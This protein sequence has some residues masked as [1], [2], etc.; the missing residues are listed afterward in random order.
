MTER[1]SDSALGAFLAR[2]TTA[3]VA[4]SSEG[5]TLG[6]H[7]DEIARAHGAEAQI[8]VQADGAVLSVLDGGDE[9]TYAVVSKQQVTRLDRFSDLIPVIRRAKDPDADLRALTAEL[10]AI[11]SSPPIYPMWTKPLGIVLFTIGF[12]PSVQ[13]TWAQIGY[14]A[15][16]G[17]VVAMVVMVADRVAR[18]AVLAPLLASF[19]VASVVLVVAAGTGPSDARIL[20]M[21]PGLFFFIPG[22]I[23]S[24]AMFDLAAGR[25]T[26]GA[27]QL[28]N[29]VFILLM[30]LTGVVFGA[31]V[32]GTD[33]STLFG[34]PADAQF[35]DLVLWAGWV[36]FT[37]GFMLAFSVRM[38]HFGWVLLV[39]L[40]VFGASLGGSALFG[41]LIGTF[42]AG[43]VLIVLAAT[44]EFRLQGPP[45]LVLA[46]AGF[47][48]LTV[49]AL[50]LEGFTGLISGDVVEG[51]TDLLKMLLVGLSLALGLLAGAVAVRQSVD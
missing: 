33:R 14:A 23:L 24:A 3:W 19:L 17:L 2:L 18:T 31:T 9:Q 39:T 7:V 34:H 16:T 6:Q 50:G 30:L 46:L 1:T 44:I 25:I 36:L 47:F 29:A 49:G 28:V 12:A 5:V 48:V 20:L 35:P 22:D 13:A 11:S 27:T 10:D 38:R 15:L 8:V 41:E 42:L 32:T 51:F 43:T 45:I 37:F 4:Y 26:T 40:V 21:V